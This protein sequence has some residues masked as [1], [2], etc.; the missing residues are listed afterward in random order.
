MRAPW[1]WHDSVETCRSVIIYKLNV[2]VPLL[3]ILIL[4]SSTS[5]TWFHIFYVIY[6]STT[7]TTS[8]TQIFLFYARVRQEHPIMSVIS[9]FTP[10]DPNSAFC[11]SWYL[12]LQSA[13]P[14][15]KQRNSC[16]CWKS[17]PFAVK[18]SSQQGFYSKEH[19]YEHLS[20]SL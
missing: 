15:G 9:L 7:M 5:S 11:P 18:P 8:D 2:I 19:K 4:F 12:G 6:F 1:R 3:V 20:V 10:E 14:Y 17:N 13:G 16:R